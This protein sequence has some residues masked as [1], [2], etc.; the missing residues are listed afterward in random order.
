MHCFTT[1]TSPSED[2]AVTNNT[3][4]GKVLVGIQVPQDASDEFDQ[5][6]EQLG[7]PW[8]EETENMAYKMF[9]CT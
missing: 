6:L 4:V 2:A 5:F 1:E 9:L 8:V 3:D 7:Y